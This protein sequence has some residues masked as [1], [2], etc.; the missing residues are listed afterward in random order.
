MTGYRKLLRS[1][2]VRSVSSVV[3]TLLVL[4]ATCAFALTD[5]RMTELEASAT[6]AE[7]RIKELGDSANEV[8]KNLLADVATKARNLI[9]AERRKRRLVGGDIPV[10]SFDGQMALLEA[11]YDEAV[12][13][14]RAY[15]ASPASTNSAP[16]DGSAPALPPG[17]APGH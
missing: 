16:S 6:A 1:K 4:T 2:S 12:R 9:M 13:R 11:E 3:S 8:H 14:L 15:E 17:L 7:T 5:E 10:P